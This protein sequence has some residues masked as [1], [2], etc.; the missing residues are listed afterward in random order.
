M[1]ENSWNQSAAR[2]HTGY[3]AVFPPGEQQRQQQIVN[4]GDRRESA[5]ILSPRCDC[6]RVETSETT[7][8]TF[9]TK[10]DDI[11]AKTYDGGKHI[12]DI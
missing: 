11:C 9:A 6:D 10:D 2:V 4:N 8:L 7:H 1:D 3:L 12:I 5:G